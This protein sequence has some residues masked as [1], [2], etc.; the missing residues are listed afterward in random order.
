MAFKRRGKPVDSDSDSFDD[1]SAGGPRSASREKKPLTPEKAEQRARNVLLHQLARGA[2][3]KHQLRKI[4][5]QREIPSEIA[6]R[7]LER[8]D[9]VGLIDDEAFAE[10]IVNSRLNFKG[11]AKSSI[12]REL[13]EKGVESFIVEAAT[14]EITSETEFEVAKNLA[15]KRYRQ[16]AHLDKAS[17]DRR[18]AGYLG[19]KGYS[20]NIVFAAIRHAQNVYEQNLDS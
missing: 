1:D 12:K 6:E 16:V 5:E 18:L 7:V 8:F 20:S 14:A 15:A 19:R 17:R 11:L 10:T 4:L 3:S 9:E 13:A 2:K